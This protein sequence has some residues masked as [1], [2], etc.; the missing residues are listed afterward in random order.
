VVATYYYYGSNNFLLCSGHARFAVDLDGTIVARV[1]PAVGW[2]TALGSM[3]NPNA[4]TLQAQY[5]GSCFE[6]RELLLRVKSGTYRIFFRRGTSAVLSALALRGTVVLATHACVEFAQKITAFLNK[7]LVTSRP[8][9]FTCFPRPCLKYIPGRLEL[10]LEDHP[11]RWHPAQ[12]GA[13][14]ALPTFTEHSAANDLALYQLM[15]INAAHFPGVGLLQWLL[16]VN[17]QLPQDLIAAH[18]LPYLIPPV[19]AIHKCIHFGCGTFKHRRSVCSM[20][21]LRDS[22]QSA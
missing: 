2:L 14:T 4:H 13:V 17:P 5:S 18:I 3:V 11:E 12:Q 6:G 1:K 15:V 9:E 21:S 16:R 19:R 8:I 10:V 7:E 20:C 22:E